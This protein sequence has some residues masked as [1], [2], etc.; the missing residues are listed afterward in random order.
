MTSDIE[1]NN[2]QKLLFREI[3]SMII[4]FISFCL[5]WPFN[6]YVLSK[7]AKIYTPPP[8]MQIITVL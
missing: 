2:Y 4:L 7:I 5:M 3:I 8:R 6:K 1:H